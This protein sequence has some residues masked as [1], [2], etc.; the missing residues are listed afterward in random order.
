MLFYGG[1]YLLCSYIVFSDLQH[2]DFTKKGTH[3][4][5]ELMY[6][7][8]HELHKKTI[9]GYRNLT[10]RHTFLHFLNYHLILK[11]SY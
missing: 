3:T 11:K 9:S 8:Q 6:Y 2:F 7:T 5:L 10:I 4:N 1:G